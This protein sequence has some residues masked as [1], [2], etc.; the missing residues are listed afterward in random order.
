M[1]EA[2]AA[3]EF[4][5]QTPKKVIVNRESPALTPNTRQR[6]SRVADKH[7]N[8]VD[9]LNLIDQNDV[10]DLVIQS[11]KNLGLYEK[12]EAVIKDAN[13]RKETRGRKMTSFTTR[14]LIGTFIMKMP[15]RQL[16]PHAPLS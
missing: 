3:D 11:M 4:L 8:F 9:A 15:L 5:L 2:S 10:V 13:P 14:K 6:K 1:P 7:T 16:S 12:L